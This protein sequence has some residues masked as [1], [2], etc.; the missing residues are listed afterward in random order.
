MLRELFEWLRD[1]GTGPGRALGL[2]REAVAIAARYRRQRAAWQPH[3]AASRQAI[4][5]ATAACP[6]HGTALIL[7][8]GACLDV[9][10]AELASRFATVVLADIHQPHPARRL[11]RAHANVRLVTADLTGLAGAALQTKR[12]GGSLP[13]PLPVPDLRL[14]TTPDLTVSANLASQLPLPVLRALAARLGENEKA[15]L[16]RAIIE[17]HF[18]AL[19][20][21]PGRV[22]LVCD[23]CWQRVENG[24]VTGTTDALSGASR[25][26]PDRT[27]VWDIAPRPEESPS[28]DR[29]NQ[30]GAWLD[31][32]AAAARPR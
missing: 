4:L 27:W 22:C 8:S 10:V 19:A 24:R 2:D 15:R 31:F 32:T 16:G 7:G 20:R 14:G 6:G 21:L 18:A 23:T 3:L 5:D 30:V 29:R 9:P 25:P 11:A 1:R 26:A 28:S 12:H 13:R 17:A